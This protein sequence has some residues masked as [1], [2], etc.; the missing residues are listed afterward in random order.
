MKNGDCGLSADDNLNTAGGVWDPTGILGDAPPPPPFTPL[1][2]VAAAVFMAPLANGDTVLLGC[3]ESVVP[4]AMS[5][6]DGMNLALMG[7]WGVETAELA[8]ES[9]RTISW[10][11][12][13]RLSW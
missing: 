13:L 11:S 9:S 7:L 8:R 5:K 2:L 12:L 3:K 4:E 1:P 6:G 10:S